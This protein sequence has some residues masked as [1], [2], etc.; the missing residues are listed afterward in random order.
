MR[1]LVNDVVGI[2]TLMFFHCFVASL[3]MRMVRYIG[4]PTVFGYRGLGN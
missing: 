3:W 1:I 4:L 2:A